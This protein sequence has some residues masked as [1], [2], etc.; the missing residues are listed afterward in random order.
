[1]TKLDQIKTTIEAL[2][3]DEV[4]RLSEWLEEL[5]GR[6][7]DEAIERDAKAGKLDMVL[8][9]VR[10]NLRADRGEDF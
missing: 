6:L 4:R 3:P 5:A 10:A 7:F 8:D 1:M 2:S 9:K